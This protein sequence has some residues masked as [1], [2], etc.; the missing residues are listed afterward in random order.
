MMGRAPRAPRAP[1][2]GRPGALRTGLRLA[3]G[4]KVGLYGGTFD[5][6][7]EGHR[8]VAEEARRRLGLNRVIWL[9]TPGNPLK[10]HHP[11]SRLAE[12]LALARRGVRGQAW[13][14]SDIEARIG[15][16]Y[17]IDTVRWFKARYPTV[18]FVW[19]MGA[20]SLA[21]FHLWRGWAD[22]AAEVP[23]AVISRPY[24]ALR[25]RFSPM[26]RR[27]AGARLPV[28]RAAALATTPPPA[29]IY[30]PAPFR[31]VSSTALRN[32]D[33]KTADARAM[34]D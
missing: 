2:A 33:L 17:T 5:P 24:V 3:G 12:R 13:S 18:R 9:V 4:L 22:L 14:V 27:F 1:R 29:W 28:A 11:T 16:R 31:F 7:H 34:E 6:P 21:G 25:S 26:A 32:S 23:I 10:T 19:I 20:D 15:S 8:H 30:F